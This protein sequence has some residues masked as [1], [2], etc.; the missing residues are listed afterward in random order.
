MKLLIVDDSTVLRNLI[1]R[2]RMT[3]Q[4][5]QVL[6]AKDG[7]QAVQIF[8]E[9]RPALVTMDI[10]MPRMDGIDCVARLVQINP[11]ARILVISALKDKATALQA[12]RNGACGFLA[13]PFSESTLSSALARAL[14]ADAAAQVS[15]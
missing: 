13:K 9:H 15:P 10:T 3:R 11:A 1:R 8:T 7:A 14:G 12:I 6:E 4:F 5:S 2:C